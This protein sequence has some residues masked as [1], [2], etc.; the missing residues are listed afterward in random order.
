[1]GLR[2]ITLC[3]HRGDAPHPRNVNPAA[4]P[5]MTANA[6]RTC[7]A[8]GLARGGRYDDRRSGDRRR[9]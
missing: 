9:S 1:M 2:L 3:L 5:F 4:S 8:L 6:H 7:D